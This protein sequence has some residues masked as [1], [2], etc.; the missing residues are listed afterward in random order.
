M[1]NCIIHA[2]GL[3]S[4][5]YV[6]KKRETVSYLQEVYVLELCFG[7]R[8]TVLY[9]RSLGLVL[10]LRSETGKLYHTYSMLM[11]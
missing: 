6:L 9:T 1:G 7:K 3:R 5:L 11:F 10:G 2:I 8:E 4:R